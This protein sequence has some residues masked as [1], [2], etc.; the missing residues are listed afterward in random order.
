MVARH[1][2][3]PFDCSFFPGAGPQDIYEVEQAVYRV[4]YK[5]FHLGLALGLPY[6]VLKSIPI[7]CLS[8]DR[9]CIEMLRLWLSMG[10]MDGDPPTRLSLVLALDS[11]LVSGQECVTSICDWYSYR[12]ERFSNLETYSIDSLMSD[13]EQRRR[14]M[15]K[16]RVH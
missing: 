8:I 2:P 10:S 1:P 14:K 7:D 12:H 11:P 5:W 16:R 3:F 4:T 9:C 15:Q 6:H 13:D